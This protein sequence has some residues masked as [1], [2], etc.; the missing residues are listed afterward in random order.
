MQLESSGLKPW[1]P[2]S[3][4]RA[5]PGVP[6]HP[7]PPHGAPGML[8]PPPLQQVFPGMSGHGP[9]PSQQQQQ[10]QQH[11]QY[12]QQHAQHA[13]QQQQQR[14]EMGHDLGAI[15]QPPQSPQRPQSRGPPPPEEL[16]IGVLMQMLP[17]G[18]ENAVAMTQDFEQA[19]QVSSPLLTSSL[20]T[21][22]QSLATQLLPSSS[23]TQRCLLNAAL[24]ITALFVH[25]RPP[26][27]PSSTHL[28]AFGRAHAGLGTAVGGG[29]P[30]V[31]VQPGGTLP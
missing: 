3:V 8:P 7:M 9:P 19:V 15:P 31:A 18:E 29:V 23:E 24:L 11:P 20:S 26:C 28:H 17:H 5:G 13:Q 6:P 30:H 16:L 2:P 22:C 1:T 12:V 14:P 4:P 21:W 27:C 25:E 10:P